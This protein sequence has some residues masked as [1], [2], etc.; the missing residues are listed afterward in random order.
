M[1]FRVHMI[2][3]ALGVATVS[4][5][6]LTINSTFIGNGVSF[7]SGLGN[8]TNAPG[9]AGTGNLTAIFNAAKSVWESKI[10][11]N[12]TVNINFGWQSLG[13]GTLGVHVLTGQ[14]GTP[15]RETDAVIRF[16]SDGSSNF[17]A[18]DT[19]L[20]NSEYNTFTEV[21]TERDLN[22]G[23]TI[24]VNEGC[25][26]TGATGFAAGNFDLFSVALHE[27][28]HALGLSGANTAFQ[29]GNGDLDVDVDFGPYNGLIIPTVNGAHINRSTALMYPFVNP[30]Q[31]N[32]I[33]DT[34][35]LANATISQFR[36]IRY[37]AV[38][39]PATLTVLGLGA[40]AAL[41]R[42]KSKA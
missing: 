34:D 27:I 14:G 2:A 18:D 21:N 16:D 3:I 39:E 28:G 13:S 1:K 42:R 26:F 36:D 9:M 29:N 8:G 4:A 38:P 23:G 5:H 15:N 41:R 40:L 19:P 11:D 20:D 25:N 35:L 33:S 17:F 31:R 32:L 6:A 24:L 12:H 22:G 7:G 10:L 30:G 37:K